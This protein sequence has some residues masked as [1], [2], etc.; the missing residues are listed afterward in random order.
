MHFLGG[1]FL[2]EHLKSPLFFIAVDAL[3]SADA[4]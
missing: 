2:H 3:Q 1:A 4:R